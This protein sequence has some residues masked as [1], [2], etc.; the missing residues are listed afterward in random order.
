MKIIKNILLWL[1]LFIWSLFVLNLAWFIDINLPKLNFNKWPDIEWTFITKEDFI[2]AST[3]SCVYPSIAT[4]RDG[5]IVCATPDDIWQLDCISPDG[6]IVVEWESIDLF[7][8]S[9]DKQQFTC[10]D[11]T[12]VIEWSWSATYDQYRYTS[13]LDSK[14]SW[15]SCTYPNKIDNTTYII[16]DGA[17]VLLYENGIVSK[18]SDCKYEVWVCNDGTIKSSLWY[19]YPSCKH[20]NIYS[21]SYLQQNVDTLI[22]ETTQGLVVNPEY[23]TDNY[24]WS[25]TCS[26]DDRYIPNGA[27]VY[28]FEDDDA[29]LWQSCNYELKVCRNG[30]FDTPNK[31][32]TSTSCNISNEWKS[33]EL[34]WWDTLSHLSSKTFYSAYDTTTKSC[35]SISVI[36]RDGS[37]WEKDDRFVY[38]SCKSTNTGTVSDQLDN[39]SNQQNNQTWSQEDQWVLCPNP[40]IWSYSAWRQWAR[41]VWYA[42]QTV[43]EWES[44]DVDK[45]GNTRKFN[46]VCQYG[47]IQPIWSRQ[48]YRSCTVWSVTTSDTNTDSTTPSPTPQVWSCTTPRWSQVNNGSSVEAYFL[49]SVAYGDFCQK[50]TRVCKDWVLWWNFQYQSCA[51]A[52]WDSCRTPWWDI[53]QHGNSVTA[54]KEAL[55]N[56]LAS[57]ESQ[58]RTCNNGAL[59]WIYLNKSCQV[60]P[61][62]DCL[63]TVYGNISHGWS[64][65]RHT[66]T[67]PCTDYS[68]VCNNGQLVWTLLSHPEATLAWS[69]PSQ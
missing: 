35:E 7:N 58:V 18:D 54:Y 66:N 28:A 10:V 51:V 55:V 23:L 59:N 63:N 11:S 21:L 4:L 29:S 36:C 38:D 64:V 15:S 9:C 69:C 49:Q 34:S 12:F 22:Q 20:T 17:T 27:S 3:P 2:T 1:I 45:D 32:Y 5:I 6:D 39:N 42:L 68:L 25:V 37:M 52:Q 14:S 16:Q 24:T 60:E 50:E 56:N 33:C 57:C 46:I 65:V 48:W 43:P 47:T 26:R 30:N 31:W 62:K 13:C 40:Y 8:S 67:T 41:W 53:I 19:W 61:P 44:C